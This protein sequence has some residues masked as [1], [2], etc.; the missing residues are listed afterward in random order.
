LDY[1]GFYDSP[2]GCLKIQFKE[3]QIYSINRASSKKCSKEF[4]MKKKPSEMRLLKS[5]LDKY[6]LKGVCDEKL[7]KKLSF[8]LR[9]TPF[10][11]KVWKVLQG[12]ACGQTCTY[13]Q[14]ARKAGSPQAFRAVGSACGRN[15]FLLLVPCHRAVAKEGLGGFALGLKAKAFLLSHEQTIKSS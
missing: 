4:L 10:Q 8:S 6:F 3:G 7:L 5:Y 9:G 14:I 12:I 11:R 13:S 2:I 1:V 15:P